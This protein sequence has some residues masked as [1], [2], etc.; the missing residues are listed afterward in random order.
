M[1]LSPNRLKVRVLGI[2]SWPIEKLIDKMAEAADY[3]R[4]RGF[5]CL[6]D[7]PAAW[8][9]YDYVLATEWARRGAPS[10]LF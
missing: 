6:D 2:E 3:N 9:E 8:R 5:D 4:S 10:R 1:L 7:C